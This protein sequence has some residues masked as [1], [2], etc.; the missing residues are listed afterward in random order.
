MNHRKQQQRLRNKEKVLT[1]G[2]QTELQYVGKGS[3]AL[4]FSATAQQPVKAVGLCCFSSCKKRGSATFCP[5]GWVPA[6]VNKQ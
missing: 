2:N 6:S 1:A 4:L 5:I 3:C